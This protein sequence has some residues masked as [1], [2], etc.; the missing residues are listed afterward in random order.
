MTR[1]RVGV[2]TGGPVLAALLL[3]AC[4]TEVRLAPDDPSWSVA[5]GVAT[6]TSDEA[7]IEVPVRSDA[8]EF[9]LRGEV[10]N[11]WGESVTVAFTP[12]VAVADVEDGRI[13][14]DDA[15]PLVAGTPYEVPRGRDGQPGRLAFALRPD[16]RW[17]ELPS[18]GA[19]VTWTVTVTT[20]WGATRCPLRFEV[21][22]ASHRPAE[23]VK[24][25]I[26][27]IAVLTVVL[28]FAF[29]V[30][31]AAG[32]ASNFKVDGIKMDPLRFDPKHL[33]Q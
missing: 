13:G 6:W 18:K 10:V 9:P 11:R 31:A 21:A 3:A 12:D 29:L 25:A 8:G 28:L 24:I 32:S 4:V 17:P 16:E 15:L 30:V 20:S 19:R 7:L 27:V 2:A 22:G 5:G 26:I 14:R 33:P 1:F 23:G